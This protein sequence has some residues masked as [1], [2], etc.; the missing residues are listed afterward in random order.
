MKHIFNPTPSPAIIQAFALLA[1][2][3]P[4]DTS[5]LSS[6]S[7]THD[8]RL[9]AAAAINMCSSLRFDQ[10][11]NDEQAL[12]ER[13]KLGEELTSQEAT[14]LTTIEQRKS[15]W[16]C[17]HNIEAMVCIGTGRGIS[18]KSTAG[19]LRSLSPLNFSTLA[20]TRKTRMTLAA[21]IFDLTES[22]LRLEMS[23]DHSKFEAFCNELAE[24]LWRFD[25]LQRVVTSVHVVTDFEVFYAHMLI[26]N[27][28]FCRLAFLVHTLRQMRMHI[29][30]SVVARGGSM[31]FHVQSD[32]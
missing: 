1:L 32:T 5:S 10:A 14:L 25:G 9:I 12:K 4:F 30:P 6:S 29:P 13:R 22:G 17:I 3:S 21:M 20:D 27:F 19:N 31:F 28:Y 16:M 23:E 8:S 11:A 7:E 15:L 24:V 26:V 18:S 2:W